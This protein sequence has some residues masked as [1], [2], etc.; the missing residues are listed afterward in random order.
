LATFN[1]EIERRIEG[2]GSDFVFR[3]LTPSGRLKHLH[4]VARLVQHVDG[5]PVFMG[6]IQDV[7]E[8]R[9]AEATLRAREAELR[10]AN[11]YLT[12]AQRLSKTGSFTWDPERNEIDWSDELFRI[13]DFRAGEKADLAQLSD[14]VHPD[15]IGTVQST[16]GRA[17]RDGVEYEIFFRIQTRDGEV[18]HLHTVGKPLTEITGRTVFVGATQDITAGK[19]A[20]DALARARAELAHVVRVATLNAM[21][22]S[23]AHEVNQPLSGILINAN[24]CLRMLDADPPDIAGAVQTAK[25]MIRDAHR[26]GDVVQRLRDMFSTRPP[27]TE[28][29]DVSEVVGEVI[30]LSTAELRQSGASLK[31]EFAKA[32]P[33]V[34][35][36]RVQ[37][38]QVILNLLLNAADAMAKVEDRPRLIVVRTGLE[39]DSAVRIDVQDSGTGLAPGAS[40]KLFDAFFTTK[41]K[42]MGV[43]LSISRTIIENHKGRLWATNNPGHGATFSVRLPAI[44][45]S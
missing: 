33:A 35:A 12:E 19:L 42:G 45:S 25:R 40:E 11:S 18:R 2:H 8:S 5:R 3:I 23:I 13:L 4:A 31:T 22:A 6:A 17:A 24:T 44:P 29:L 43:G 39:A 36:D 26:A 14:M 34:G 9:F 1:A 20:D 37:L 32:L 30:A 28:P 38:Q 21:T 41:V 10:R 15:D 7:T 16:L 27:T